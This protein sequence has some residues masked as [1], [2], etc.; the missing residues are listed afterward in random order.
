MPN[1]KALENGPCTWF[2]RSAG[3]VHLR[4]CAARGYNYWT[5]QEIV[6]E[7]SADYFRDEL[8]KYQTVKEIRVY[9]NSFGGSVEEALPI[10]NQLKRHTAKVVGIVD[11]FAASA[12]SFILT[13]CDEVKMYANTTQ[14]LHNM[15][16]MSYG[17]SSAHRK[18]AD[19]QDVIMTA[20]RQGYLEKAGGKLTDEQL[21]VILENETWL[22]AQQCF[23][24]GL[25][26]EVISDEV[27]LTAA[28]AMLEQANMTMEQH[29]AVRMAMA[30]Q[31][32]E[33]T[34]LTK[35]E[36]TPPE[37]ETTPPEPTP[38]PKTNG[39]KLM[40]IFNKTKG[41]HTHA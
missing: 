33:L 1:E 3:T 28:K 20:I 21:M 12:A 31:I 10:R 41:G 4:I 9:V 25:C 22:T 34:M 18:A 32:K 2:E 38:T 14:M 35:T 6:S 36:P 27:D 15:L 24:Y 5:G 16:G 40:A 29:I 19:D 7:T 8:A 30:T 37:P 26:D 23:D 17:N 11:G 13:G 39:E